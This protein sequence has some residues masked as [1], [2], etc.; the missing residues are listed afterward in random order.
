MISWKW[1]NGEE[2]YRSPRQQPPKIKQGEQNGFDSSI[3]AINQSLDET[4]FQSYDSDLMNITNSMFQQNLEANTSMREELDNKMT[5]R[6]QVQQCG[7]NPF[8]GQ[9]SYVNDIITR[10][11]YLKP[12]NTTNGER[13]ASNQT[14]NS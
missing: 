9:T 2:H 8:L 1:S 7:N 13:K 12:I 10:D 11:M 3:N 4:F 6:D 5:E 14:Y